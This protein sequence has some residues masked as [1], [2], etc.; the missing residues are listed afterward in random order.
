MLLFNVEFPSKGLNDKMNVQHADYPEIGDIWESPDYAEHSFCV[1]FKSDSV[2]GI[3]STKE[4]SSLL[5]SLDLENLT[6]YTIE[7]WNSMIPALVEQHGY[8]W[9]INAIIDDEQSKIIQSYID[10]EFDVDSSSTETES[11]DTEE[12][13]EKEKVY[14]KLEVESTPD[15]C[16]FCGRESRLV[17]A[18]TNFCVR[19]AGKVFSLPL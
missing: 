10:K 11:E 19:C 9:I 14:G 18:K 7:G 4:V 16:Y 17:F 3:T 12:K 8:T 5:F 13:E 2:I 15:L 1:V 6:M